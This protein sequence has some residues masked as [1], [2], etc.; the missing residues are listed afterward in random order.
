MITNVLPVEATH[1]SLDLF[2][3]PS[4]LVAFDSAFEQ[5]VGPV[6]APNGPTLEFKVVGDRHNFIDLQRIYLE[7]SCS[8]HKQ[9]GNALVY[10]GGHDV[11]ASD[12]PKF[13]NNTLHSLFS[14]CDIFANGVKISTANGVYGHKS[15]LET[16]MSHSNEAKSTWLKCQGY[17]YEALPGTTTHDDINGRE[18]STRQSAVVSFIG[19]LSV[20]FFTCD[21]LRIPDVALR[22]KLL[23]AHND[24]IVISDAADKHYTVK[25]RDANLY[26]RKM[27]VA[28]NVFTSIERVLLKTPVMYRYTEVLPKTFIIPNGQNSWKHED[29]FMKEP[30]R[31]LAIAMNTNTAFGASN[32]S[33]PFNYQKFGLRSITLYRNGIPMGGTPLET[34]HNQRAYFN[35][36]TSLAFGHLSHGIPLN[37]YEAGH[38]ILVFD[39]TST[40]EASH[41]FIHPELTNASISIDMTF[42]T[43]LV[44][45]IEVFL[46]GEKSSTIF[47]DSA[48]NVSKN[49][50]FGV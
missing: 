9:D 28:E 30:I 37:E 18:E 6:Y 33:N 7:L 35:T 48:R 31:R 16:E 22:V 5:K 3:R 32:T 38:F 1:S 2:E 44:N 46:L 19:K 41:E 29:V 11:A 40:L 17:N 20:D 39:L 34:T 27:V 50:L 26:V 47:I 21:K 45:P 10:D 23:R 8:I 43:A 24:F 13:V 15:F 49:V 14:E 42:N 4:L 12:E 25:I 36:L